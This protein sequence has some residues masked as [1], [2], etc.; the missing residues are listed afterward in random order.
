MAVRVH[1][2]MKSQRLSIEPL[3]ELY[4]SACDERVP[5]AL[6]R[7]RVFDGERDVSEAAW[8]VRGLY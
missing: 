2:P 5:Y 4:V 6:S 1:F 3:R 7:L 8:V